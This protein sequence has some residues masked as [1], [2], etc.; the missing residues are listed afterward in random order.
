MNLKKTHVI[1]KIEFIILKT[2]TFYVSGI[3][4]VYIHIYIL[5]WIEFSL[6]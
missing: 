4:I 5:K 1:R 2:N 6:T 3:N